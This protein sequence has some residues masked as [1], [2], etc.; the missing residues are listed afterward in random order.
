MLAV[1]HLFPVPEIIV[2]KKTG[3]V[4]ERTLY[5]GSEAG[6]GEDLTYAGASDVPSTSPSHGYNLHQWSTWSRHGETCS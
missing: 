2:P 6:T 1:F 5:V 4:P 3:T